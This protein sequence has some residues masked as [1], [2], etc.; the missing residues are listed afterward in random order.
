MDSA[1]YELFH[2]CTVRLV[3]TSSHEQGTGFFVAPGF[4]LTCA[5]VVKKVVTHPQALEVSWKAQ[6]YSAQKIEPFDTVD[7]ALVQ[8]TSFPDH[9]C[10]FLNEDMAPSDS[11]YSY[12]Y[13]AKHA[14][15]DSATFG[16]EGW[17]Q[18]R[19]ETL[20]KF[21]AGQVEP[22]MSGSPLLNERTGHVCGVIAFT[23]DRSTAQGGRAI[24]TR[25]IWQVLPMLKRQQEEFHQIDQ[26]WVA[27]LESFQ[28]G[29]QK[30]EAQE[31]KNALPDAQQ[32]ETQK[33]T[34]KIE[35]GAQIQGAIVNI[36][37]Q[38]DLSGNVTITFQD[39]QLFGGKSPEEKS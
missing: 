4:I 19:N 2:Q 34:I 12:G 22:G 25:T 32:S 33:N 29:K 21:K 9:P 8:V 16:A 5:H 1:L 7:L 15:G 24:W 37:G 13:P 35:S 17:T 27:R 14:D 30:R 26:R 36:G 28:F 38:T 11:L 23:R 10:V 18:L 3:D 20:L 39:T 6:I 31:P